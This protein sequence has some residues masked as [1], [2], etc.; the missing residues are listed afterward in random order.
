[1]PRTNIRL[2]CV[3]DHPLV[4]KGLTQAI[5][6]EPDLTV[7]AVA[8]TGEDAV[9]CYRKHRPDITMMD[10]H[11][12]GMS[13]LE[14]IAAIRSEDSSAKIIVLTMYHGDEDIHRAMKAGAAAYVLK[15]TAPEDLLRVVR[16]VASGAR[17]M[18][19]EVASQLSRRYTMPALTVR[20]IKVVELMALGMR[21]K[22]IAAELGI[23]EVTVEAH[24]R[25]IFAK[26]K[27]NDRTLAV[28]V[29]LRRGIIHLA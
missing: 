29:A 13:G 2:L 28:T 1:M 7:V 20:E 24:A 11:L 12:P 21:N 25:N 4:L 14:A 22:E 18:A 26:L 6:L 17:P 16:E 9:V 23:S 27:V 8:S 15:T 19:T 5:G 3:D 10:L